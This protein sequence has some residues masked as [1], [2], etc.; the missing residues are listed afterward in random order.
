MQLSLMLFEGN[1][2]PMSRRGACLDNV[3]VEKLTESLE[4]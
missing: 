1:F 2:A 3:V 4:M